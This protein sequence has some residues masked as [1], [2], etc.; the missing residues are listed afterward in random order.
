[1]TEAFSKWAIDRWA[2]RHG[3]TYSMGPMQYDHELLRAFVREVVIGAE[4]WRPISYAEQEYGDPVGES[5]RKVVK[6]FGL[7]EQ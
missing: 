1:M 6:D 3:K 4:N 2:A 5:F 7:E